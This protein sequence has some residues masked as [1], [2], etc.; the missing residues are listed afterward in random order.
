MVPGQAMEDTGCRSNR[1]CVIKTGRCYLGTD[2]NNNVGMCGC[3]N[4]LS[5]YPLCESQRRNDDANKCDEDCSVGNGKCSADGTC[6]CSF[7]GLWPKT[8]CRGLCPL[9]QSCYMGQCECMYGELPNGECTR[10]KNPCG[11]LEECNESRKNAQCQCKYGGT[12]PRCKENDLRDECNKHCGPESSCR[13]AS[14]RAAFYY[15]S[16]SIKTTTLK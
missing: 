16:C 3:K 1:D 14:G 6:M 15:T 7:G 8:C 9:G 4:G 11:E 13:K 5:N 2:D 12:W 10:C